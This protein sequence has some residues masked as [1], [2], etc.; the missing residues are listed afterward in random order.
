QSL[1]D[2]RLSLCTVTD[3]KHLGPT[4]FEPPIE[5]DQQWAVKSKIDNE[6]Q[7]E[8]VK[9]ACDVCRQVSVD[10]FEFLLKSIDRPLCGLERLKKD[11]IFVGRLV[12]VKRIFSRCCLTDEQDR[13]L[14]SWMRESATVQLISHI[15]FKAVRDR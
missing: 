15:H 5:W 4:L 11:K 6:M 3:D 1:S 12:G 9:D 10:C 14:R 7:V 8:S 13:L 2:F